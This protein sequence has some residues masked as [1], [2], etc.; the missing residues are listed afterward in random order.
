MSFKEFIKTILLIVLPVLI[1][2]ISQA[3]A[4][5]FITENYIIQLVLVVLLAIIDAFLEIK[6]ILFVSDHNWI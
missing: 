5:F 6:W 4:I 3:I 2:V 1:I